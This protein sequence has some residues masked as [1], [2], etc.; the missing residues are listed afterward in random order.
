MILSIFSPIDL[1]TIGRREKKVKLRENIRYL[2]T[3]VVDLM[4]PHPL[5]GMLMK[6]WQLKNVEKY[7]IYKI[8]LVV[9]WEFE[10]KAIL[11]KNS[12]LSVLGKE[13]EKDLT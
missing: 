7:S 8:D 2:D 1:V 3:S 5:E 4:K 11:D 13:D 12:S 9:W 10:T 6:Y